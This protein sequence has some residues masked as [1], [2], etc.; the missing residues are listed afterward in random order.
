MRVTH[1]LIL[2]PMALISVWFV[3]LLLRSRT[4]GAARRA[5]RAHYFDACKGLFTSVKSGVSLHG[6]Q[7]LNGTYRGRLFDLQAL[8]DTL[9]YRKLP[10]LW[11][12]VTI[13]A[14]T[15]LS[16]TTDLMA[17]ANGGEVFSKFGQLPVQIGTPSGFPDDVVVRTDDPGALPGPEVVELLRL[18]FRAERLKEMVLAPDGLRLVWLAEEADRTRYLIFRDSEMGAVPLAREELSPLLDRM[19]SLADLLEIKDAT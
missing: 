10:S 7:R 2:L 3:T 15:G 1:Y 19:A 12:L 16:A 18:A 14:R 13:P 6:Y 5:A 8:P 9:T 17:R 11:L 4:A